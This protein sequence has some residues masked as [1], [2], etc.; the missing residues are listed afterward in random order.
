MSKGTRKSSC[1][2]NAL[3]RKARKIGYIDP[4][5]YYLIVCEGKKTEPEYFK[6]IKDLI[7]AHYDHRVEVKQVAIDIRGE[8]TNTLFLLER[9]KQ[10]VE[11]LR[12]QVTQV[13]LVYDKDDFP[14]DRFDTTQSEAG[15]LSRESGINFNVAWSNQCIEYWFLLHFE[16]LQSDLTRDHYI[17]KLNGHFERVGIGRYRKNRSKMFS[18]LL[19]HGNLELAIRWAKQRMLDHVGKTP[20]QSVPATRVHELVEELSRYIPKIKGRLIKTE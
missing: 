13:W 8:A 10:Y 18:L 6:E 1:P 2:V 9:A 19:K 5:E 17:R 7:N 16:N 20:S 3:G 4:L 15:R 14:P 11:E 12:G